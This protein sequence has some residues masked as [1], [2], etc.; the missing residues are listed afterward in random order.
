[1]SD[2]TNLPATAQAATVVATDE[3]SMSVGNMWASMIEMARDPSVDAAKI[4]HLVGLQEQMIDRAAKD[5]FDRAFAKA[6]QNMPVITKDDKIEHNNRFIGWF[7]KYEDLRS[8][9]DQVI[10]PL[11]LTVTHD[12]DQIDGGKGGV[13]VWTVITYM[14]DE[15]TWREERGRMPVPPDGGGAKSAAQAL[16]SSVTYGQRYSLAAAFGIVQKGLDRDGRTKAPEQR[17]ESWQDQVKDDAMKAAGQGSAAYS[18]FFAKLSPMKKGWL[19]EFG[20]HAQMKQGAEA[21]DNPA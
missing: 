2:E 1:M 10:N 7:K 6:C 11:G 20:G 13:T 9:V 12:S 14:D 5:K 21:H 4:G 15:Y 8:I 19:V 17:G 16:G 18:E 3:N